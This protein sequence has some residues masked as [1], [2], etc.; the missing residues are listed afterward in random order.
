MAE[1]ITEANKPANPKT[2][3]ESIVEFY[4]G[5]DL[6]EI[7]KTE[8]FGLIEEIC[9]PIKSRSNDLSVVN[10]SVL[11][12]KPYEVRLPKLKA[13]NGDLVVTTRTARFM[14]ES[15][16]LDAIAYITNVLQERLKKM[17]EALKNFKKFADWICSSANKEAH[18]DLMTQEQE[19]PARPGSLPLS[20]LEKIVRDSFNTPATTM[21][22]SA[23]VS[24]RKTLLDYATD[25]YGESFELA[26]IEDLKKAIYSCA[27]SLTEY[28]SITFEKEQ[29]DVAYTMK[30]EAGQKEALICIEVLSAIAR[31]RLEEKKN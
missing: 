9:N 3:T 20:E 5:E 8:L 4:G 26:S 15:E 19:P 1:Y 17:T 21:D 24:P 6:P 29:N 28:Y 27:E 12:I 18:G 30:T 16:G 14:F 7:S 13:E 10:P 23:P 11:W 25:F 22:V 2:L 31:K